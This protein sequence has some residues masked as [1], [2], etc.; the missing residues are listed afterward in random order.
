MIGSAGDLPPQAAIS[1]ERF[2]A[3]EREAKT[4][5][6]FLK[7]RGLLEEDPKRVSDTLW[8]VVLKRGDS[9]SGPI[10]DEIA[11]KYRDSSPEV[12]VY[13]GSYGGTPSFYLSAGPLPPGSTTQSGGALTLVGS[14]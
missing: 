9:R 5:A 2:F 7:S 4:I 11:Q 6:S 13:A 12:Y 1:E 10:A 8:R 14:P 3:P